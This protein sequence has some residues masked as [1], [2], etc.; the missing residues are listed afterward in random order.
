[1]EFEMSQ[2]RMSVKDIPADQWWPAD[3]PLQVYPERGPQVA[4]IEMGA[5]DLATLEAKVFELKQK[6]NLVPMGCDGRYYYFMK[7]TRPVILQPGQRHPGL[8]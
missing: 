1:M 5:Y 4:R 7:D 6:L 3:D 2:Q 8:N